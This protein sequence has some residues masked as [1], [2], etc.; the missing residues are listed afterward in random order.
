[1]HPGID[2]LCPPKIK[3]LIKIDVSMNVER[4]GL[5]HR[6]VQWRV[7]RYVLRIEYI[8]P[9]PIAASSPIRS[10]GHSSGPIGHHRRTLGWSGG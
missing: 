2:V 8:S 10:L 9:H 7:A 4:R 6:S 5:R 3:S 1:M